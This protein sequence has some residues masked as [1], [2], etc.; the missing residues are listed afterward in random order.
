MALSETR[1]YES[2]PPYHDPGA[3]ISPKESVKQEGKFKPS[4]FDR[5]HFIARKTLTRIFLPPEE[6]EPILTNSW[7]NVGKDGKTWYGIQLPHNCPDHLLDKVVSVHFHEGQKDKKPTWCNHCKAPVDVDIKSLQQE[8][9]SSG[10]IS[11]I[12]KHINR[13]QGKNGLRF[14][15]PRIHSDSELL[16]QPEPWIGRIYK[17][18]IQ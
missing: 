9:L 17:L 11:K 16:D 5:F 7:T 2:A 3:L 14:I 18:P 8:I 10:L 6:F 12:R 13:V 4:F 1:I 15:T